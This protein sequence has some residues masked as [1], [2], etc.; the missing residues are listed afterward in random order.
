VEVRK[1]VK[2]RLLN[3]TI[4]LLVYCFLLTAFFDPQP[5]YL[6]GYV[7]GGAIGIPIVLLI[8]AFLTIYYSLRGGGNWSRA[9]RNLKNNF[10]AMLSVGWRD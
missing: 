5:S 9:R 8:I 6:R 4:Y 3:G 7:R 10:L 1:I 2:R